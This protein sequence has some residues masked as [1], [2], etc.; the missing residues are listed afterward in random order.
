MK[1]F[2]MISMLLIAAL[3]VVSCGDGEEGGEG[4]NDACTEQG[5]LRCSGDMV[6]KCDQEVWKNF[7]NCADAGKTCNAG[8]CE[9]AGD[10]GDTTPDD[11]S[12]TAPDNGDTTPDDGDTAPAAGLNC[13]EIYQC[14]VNCGQDGNCQ[15]DCYNN[16][17][18][19]GQTQIYALI[20]CLN[21]CSDSTTTDDEFQEC[22]NNQCSTE[23]SNCEGLGG[24][25]AADTSYNSP[26]GTLTLNF[27]IDQ[28]ANDTDGQTSQVGIAQAAFANGTYGNGVMSVTPPDAYMIQSNA[29]Y[30]VD[31]QYG[32]SIS[33]QQIPVYVQGQQA[34][35]GNPI[36]ALSIYEEYAAIG[37]INSSIYQGAQAQLFV[38]DVNWSTQQIS[39]I[40]AFGEGDINIT[41]IGDYANHGGIT[42]NGNITLYSPK[43]YNGNGDI[44]A[45]LG[46]PACNVVQ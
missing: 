17:S 42:F 15:Q 12:D 28:I 4:G 35:G 19:D 8:K 39:C 34:V 6:Q 20:E 10:N 38:A 44:S 31:A 25:E 7:E 5:A 41:N 30:S 33:V 16:G 13:G 45:Q 9:A 24:G 11:G 43:N 26:Y 32:N 40:H 29:M 21:T 3:F 36:V 22:A 46:V 18:A 2:W 23:I 14:M 27:S 37:T 1:K